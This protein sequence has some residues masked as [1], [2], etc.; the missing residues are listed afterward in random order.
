MVEAP[1]NCTVKRKFFLRKTRGTRQNQLSIHTKKR[2]RRANAK[3]KPQPRR[4]ACRGMVEAPEK[5][6]VKHEFFFR[7]TRGTRQRELKFFK[8]PPP[9]PL[10]PIFHDDKIIKSI[11]IYYIAKQ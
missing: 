4:R 9:R 5:C 7:K 3:A 11:Y 8:F 2:E 10:T 1:E 6:T